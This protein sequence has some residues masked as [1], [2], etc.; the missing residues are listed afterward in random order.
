M[1]D[2]HVGI[3][4][5]E[6]AL[7]S[8]YKQDAGVIKKLLQGYYKTNEFDKVVFCAEQINSKAD[9]TGSRNQFL[10]GLAL[11]KQ[12]RSEEAEENVKSID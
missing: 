8:N 5:Y 11:D 3:D 6:I 4:E 9:F 10:Y 2:Y 12:G 7:K 1:K